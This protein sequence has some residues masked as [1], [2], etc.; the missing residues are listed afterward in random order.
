MTTSVT[1]V[2]LFD[3][4]WAAWLRGVETCRRKPSCQAV[5]ALRIDCRRLEALLDAL[6][7]TTGA[8]ARSLRRLRKVAGE[9]IEALSALRDDQVHRR[10]IARAGD[11]RGLDALLEHVRHQQARHKKRARRKLARIDLAKADALAHRVR[12]GVVQRQGAPTPDDRALLLLT[13]VDAAATQVRSRLARL[14]R[15]K[16]RSLHKL[17]VSIKRFRYIV[18]VAEEVSPSVRIASVPT[19]RS[20]QRHLGIVHD[21]D[22]LASRIRR[23]S[24]RRRRYLRDV[25]TLAK[26]VERDRARHVRKLSRA[27]PVM[28]HALT[29]LAARAAS[30]S[31][32]YTPS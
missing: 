4:S 15:D 12:A 29:D 1:L 10:T 23:F 21:A 8:S 18:E 28:R 22:V 30:G 26:G 31:A 27:L 17:R 3:R 9:P 24:R 14:D 6:G 25:R 20:L 32:H 7:Y 19:L 11:N 13:A 16:P 2:R 5:H